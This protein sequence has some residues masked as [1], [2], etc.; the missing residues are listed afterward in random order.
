MALF[1]KK[2]EQVPDAAEN[3]AAEASAV[4][5]KKKGATMASVLHE[6][7]KETALDVMRGNTPFRTAR[8]GEPAYACLLLKA[9]DIGGLSKK[10][11]RDEGKGSLVECINNGRVRTYATKAML[12]D[13]RVVIIPTESTLDNM[14]EFGFLE[15]APYELAL[16]DEDGGV[17]LTGVPLTLETA[18]E[19]V[20]GTRELS[21]L[22]SEDELDEDEDLDLVDDDDDDLDDDDG[23]DVGDGEDV[24]LDD[25]DDYLDD[26][27]YDYDGDDDDFD[28]DEDDDY[29]LDEDDEDADLPVEDEDEEDDGLVVGAE[30][31]VRTIRR[32]YYSDDLGMEITDD[33]FFAQFM[34]GNPQVLFPE[35]RPEGFINNYLNEMSRMANAVLHNMHEQNLF[36][37]REKYF[38]L[39]SAGVELIQKELDITNG[40]TTFGK[41]YAAILGERKQ[42]LENL[43]QTVAQRRSL[44]DSEWEKS[45]A[46][47]GEAAALTARQQYEERHG[48]SHKEAIFRLESEVQQEILQAAEN[49]EREMYAR[50]KDEAQTKLDYT[51]SRTLAE[52][53]TLY[54]GMLQEEQAAYK[55]YADEMRAFADGNRKDEIARS[56]ALAEELARNNKAEQIMQETNVKIAA[57]RADN[58]AK[59]NEL[60]AKIREKEQKAEADLAARQAAMEAQAAAYDQKLASADERYLRLQEAYE[61]LNES[62]HAEYEG[63]INQLTQDRV[64]AEQHT[65]YILRS[66]R[67]SNKIA[68]IVVAAALLAF[69]ALGIIGGYW[70]GA[71]NTRELIAEINQPQQTVTAQL[72]AEEAPADGAGQ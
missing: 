21:D 65:E 34:A 64:S 72:P 8:E 11:S 56:N 59:A 35:D 55:Q 7:V 33:P 69:A 61:K 47:A 24:D 42:K 4:K 1:G 43:G 39:M 49:N 3:A 67:R 57:L 45:L 60:Q 15:A 16:V 51:I 50:R 25:D 52:L 41:A 44:I 12:D 58:E 70:F 2:K 26:D 29:G 68:S 9:E 40:E 23:A 38:A 48:R 22:W 46:Q 14:A 66:H 13:D 37:L 18:V 32:R 10:E 19:V 30:E 36:A 63:R 31:V 28:L 6:S 54:T 17:F 71:K 5:P 27:D 53:S 20:M 62:V